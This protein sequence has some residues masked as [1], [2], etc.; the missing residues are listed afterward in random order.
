MKIVP[1]KPEWGQTLQPGFCGFIT[2][3]HDLVGDGIEYFEHFETGLPFV[4]TFIIESLGQTSNS[5][6]TAGIPRR[7]GG[8]GK[9]EG[10]QIEII[11]A[12]AGTG[13]ARA[14]LN[15]YLDNGGPGAGRCQCFIRMPLGWTP[16]IGQKIIN[17]AAVHLGERYA[18][19]LILA[20]ALA[21][22]FLGHCLNRLTF[23]LP[24]RF[25]C[26]ALSNAH[27]KICSQLVALALQ[28]Q[29]Y[30]RLR[31]CLRRPAD[32]ILPKELGNDPSIWDPVIYKIS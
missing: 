19:S 8:E 18:F 25:V 27:R 22:T 9:G 16:A 21:N 32:T 11:E 7:L 4:H 30:L 23:N 5:G 1:A 20:D 29:F 31:G 13:V 28:A 10:E 26:W 12:H 17:A 2:R 24:D 14:T 15:Q 6:S 3:E